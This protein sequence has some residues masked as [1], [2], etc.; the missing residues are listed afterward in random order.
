VKDK[1]L[2]LLLSEIRSQ[3]PNEL[4]MQKWKNAV[5]NELR[6]NKKPK[7]VFW[8]QLAAASVIGFL[9]GAVVFKNTKQEDSFQNLAQF[10]G[11]NATVEYV[12][13]KTN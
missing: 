11:D 8:M 2:D 5:R 1:D 6:T 10:D 9:V 7:R 13:T 4:Q 12:L 3:T